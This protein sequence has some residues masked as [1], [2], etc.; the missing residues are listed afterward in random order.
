MLFVFVNKIVISDKIVILGSVQCQLF[1]SSIK[2]KGCHRLI[3]ECHKMTSVTLLGVL[4][5]TTIVMAC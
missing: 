4:R 2:D 3:I 1:R 5:G